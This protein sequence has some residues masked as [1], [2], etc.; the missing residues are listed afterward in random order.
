VVWDA[1]PRELTVN[2]VLQIIQGSTIGIQIVVVRNLFAALLAG[3]A[4]GQGGYATA[5]E[6]LGIMVG[7]Q[8]ISGAIGIYQNQQQQLLT[9]L[10][11]Q[12]A[13]KPVMEV[14]STIDLRDFDTP[15]FHD[16]LDRAKTTATTRPMQVTTAVMSLGR[17]LLGLVG[18]GFGLLVISPILFLTTLA[19]CLPLW[20]V[21]ASTAKTGFQFTKKMTTNDRLRAYVLGLLTQ[22]DM[23][24]EV[25]A[26]GL[27]G[28]LRERYELLSRERIKE[29]RQHIRRRA[30]TAAAGSTGTTVVFALTLIAVAWLVVNH[31]L[32]LAEAGAGVTS[33]LGL[34][35]QLQTLTQSASQLYQ[36]SLFVEDLRDFLSLLPVVKATRPTSAAPRGFSRIV[37]RDVSFSYPTTRVRTTPGTP[38]QKNGLARPGIIAGEGDDGRTNALHGVSME[39][40]R[41]QVVALVGEN[42]SGKTTLAKLLCGLYRP[43]SGAVLW[44]NVDASEVHPDQLRDQVTVLFQDFGRYMFTARENISL[45]RVERRDD[46]EAIRAACRDAGATD[47]IESLPEGYETP[48]GPI[49]PGGQ[50]LSIG[51]WQR[52]A[53]ARAFF[54]DAPL[55]I[56]DEPTASIDAKAEAELFERIR[57]HFEGRSVVL[58][59]HRFS[60]VRSADW[61]YVLREG[62]VIEQGTHARLLQMGGHYAELFNLQAASYH[63]DDSPARD[64]RPCERDDLSSAEGTEGNL[65]ILEIEGGAAASA[66][67]PGRPAGPPP[68][69]AARGPSPPSR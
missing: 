57:S 5:V 23:A 8:V 53:L 1:A 25:R 68:T 55:V 3:R 62:R 18:L 61:I 38:A 10:V 2:V 35:G 26:F 46:F 34:S 36:S 44:D 6:Q 27:G 28:F 43:D 20:L 7:L 63:T 42:G 56:L 22:R 67:S 65:A 37:V 49:F 39:I 66:T 58:I 15:D 52:V 33:A 13:V 12:H 32:G 50:E 21:G 48:F 47:F 4:P 24:K 69:R 51:Q 29:L 54:R 64:G 14:A 30:L 31:H 60:S 41:G 59:S 16:R 17:S 40:D 9:E 19:G 45:G 11:Q